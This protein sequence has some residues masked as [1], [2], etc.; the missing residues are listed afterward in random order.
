M[1]LSKIYIRW[2][3]AVIFSGGRRILF[4]FFFRGDQD[5][6][7]SSSDQFS[8]IAFMASSNQDEMEEEET[9]D[10]QED[11]MSGDEDMDQEEDQQYP[12]AEAT[13]TVE[14]GKRRTSKCWKHFKVIGPKYPDGRSDCRCIVAIIHTA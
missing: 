13:S 1:T 11:Y 14:R 8:L 10:L 7:S 4:F 3:Y 9:V 6:P 12:P 5:E 2:S